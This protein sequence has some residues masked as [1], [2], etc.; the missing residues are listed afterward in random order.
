M[1]EDRADFDPTVHPYILTTLGIRYPLGITQNF[2]KAIKTGEPYPIKVLFLIGCDMRA[3]HS[4]EWKEA[5]QKV[6]FIVKSHVWPDDDVDYADLVLPEATYLER[7]DGFEVVRALDPEDKD[8]E[9]TFLA[10][11][12]KVVEPQF[13]ERPW[14]DYIKELSQRIGFGESYDFSLDEY[15]NFLLAPTGIDIGYLRKH[16]VYCPTP[17]GRKKVEF[18][19][20]ERWATDTGRLNLYGCEMV[21]RWYKGNQNPLFDPL[22]IYHP[23]SVEPKAE[24]E[25][26]LINGKCSYFWCNFYR[27]NPM[28]L[29]RYLEGDLG[30]TL[31][32]INARRAALLGIRDRDWVWIES[33]ATRIKEKVRVKVTEGIHPAAVWH[34]YGYGHKS[35]L[36]D[37]A[38]R[39]RDGINV[40]DFVPERSVPWT[41]GQAHCEAVVKIC[42]DRGEG[43]G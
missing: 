36:M 5:F 27:N 7:D 23:T 21:D 18:G 33:E 37:K 41:A 40:N 42:K 2:L 34:V 25:F 30:N 9:F 20:K 26:Y 1:T 12:P 43:N 39:A 29:E 15:W 10:V 3:S 31:L 16:G 38:S 14:T 35:S 11:T 6:D 24:N 17:L 32:W 13:E 28:L 4:P 22:P 8:A 19:K